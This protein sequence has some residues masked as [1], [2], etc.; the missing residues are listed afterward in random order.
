MINNIYINTHKRELGGSSDAHRQYNRALVPILKNTLVDAELDDIQI[1]D[2]KGEHHC[3]N[4]GNR[5]KL[6]IFINGTV[7]GAGDDVKLE[8]AQPIGGISNQFV[9]YLQPGNFENNIVIYGDA[10]TPIAQYN[11]NYNELNILFNL[12]NSYSET[13]VK[14]FEFIMKK[15]NELVFKPLTM[16]NSWKSTT[17]R[18]GLTERFTRQV[19]DAKE[20]FLRQDKSDLAVFEREIENYKR[21]IKQ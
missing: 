4:A 11:Q 21:K 9:N 16:I 14:I 5:R 3:Y 15:L 17:D 19:K 10:G 8:S 20:R 7:R 1:Y 13:N 12:F 6:V 18:A 2:I